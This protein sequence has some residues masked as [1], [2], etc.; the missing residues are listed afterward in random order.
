LAV[1]LLAAG[2]LGWHL[3]TAGQESTDDAQ[4]EA[5]V[6]PLAS[7]VSGQVEKVWVKENAFVKAGE[8][9]VDVDPA[10][11]RIRV[12]EAEGELTSATAQAR[13][14]DAQVEVA[15]AMAKGGLSSAQASVSG[16]HAAVSTAEAQ[17]A[18]ARAAIARAQADATRAQKELERAQ[19]L[20]EANAIPQQRLDD[21]RAASASAD[22]ALLQ[23]KAQLSSAEES[24]RLAQSRVAEAQGQ[25]ASS[26]PIDSKIAVAQA[27]AQLAHGRVTTAQAA[28][29]QA[30]LQLGYTHV[31]APRDGR[32]ARLGV[33]PG[34]LVSAGAPLAQLVPTETYVVA[35]FKE[36]QIQHMRP[37]QKVEIS[38]DALDGTLEGTVESLAAGTGS[39]F[40]LLPPDNAS[41]NFVKVVQRVPVRI[42]F[43]DAKKTSRLKAGLSADVTVYTE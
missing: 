20:R 42:A 3:L 5:D 9:L 30:R 1:T 32:V 28:L 37:G 36:T 25:L 6:V 7:R 19:A 21:A 2:G 18:A 4:I 12:Q 38:V 17:V 24:R 33:H 31:V 27:N 40:A 43:T 13:A 16:S 15:E 10:P 23:A 8:P 29:D 35:N 26:A 11:Y 41:G 14:A 22:A 34:Q 39:R